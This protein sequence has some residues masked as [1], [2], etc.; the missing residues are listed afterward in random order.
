LGVLGRWAARSPLR[1]DAAFKRRSLMLSF[2]TMFD[3]SRAKGLNAHIG[4]RIGDGRSSCN[5]SR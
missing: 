2:K 1:S 5:P 3:A 4:F